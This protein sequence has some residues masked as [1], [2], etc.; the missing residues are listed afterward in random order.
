[1]SRVVVDTDVVSFIFKNHAIGALYE[2]D[3]AER[4]LLVSFMTLAEL[5]RWAIQSKWGELYLE[6]FVIL[7]YSRRLCTIWAEVT[8][9]AQSRGCRI[10][11]ADAWIA[12]AVL[13]HDVPLVTHNRGDYLGV[14]G[15]KLISHGPLGGPSTN[16]PVFGPVAG[17]SV[18]SFHPPPGAPGGSRRRR[19]PLTRFTEFTRFRHCW[20]VRTPS[21]TEWSGNTRKPCLAY[22]RAAP[23]QLTASL[24]PP[25]GWSAAA[26]AS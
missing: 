10:E 9:A 12:A 25:C 23:R 7:P 21:R 1:M 8:V 24:Q 16:Q 11:C 6:R 18:P 14:P 5:E 22:S 19:S 15:L 4:T 13:R 2:S 17:H 3:L 26:R 20:Q